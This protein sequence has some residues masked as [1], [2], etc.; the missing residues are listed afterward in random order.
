MRRQIPAALSSA[1]VA[2]MAASALVI[3][4]AG[5][6]AASK[7]RQVHTSI[8]DLM[9]SI[10]DPSADVIWGASGTIVDKDQGTVELFPKTAEGWMDVRRAAVRIIEGANLLMTPGRL[11]A[12]A[13]AKSAT[14]GVELE[15]AEIMV[16]I[17]R[18]RAGFDSFATALRDLGWEALQ[19]SEAQ[20]TEALLDVGGRMQE[21]CEGCH[22]TFWY[23]NASAPYAGG[24]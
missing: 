15:P 17:N 22:Q 13:G 16:L 1:V 10:V 21:A 5:S 4:Q 2:L 18:N 6:I 23:P 8:R 14:P 12:P 3:A 20:S 19:A 9:D 7:D 11:S 24:R